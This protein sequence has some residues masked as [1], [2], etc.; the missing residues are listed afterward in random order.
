[1]TALRHMNHA[2]FGTLMALEPAIGVMLGLVVLHQRP[3]LVQTLGIVLVVVA[4]AAAARNGR[5]GPA[6]AYLTPE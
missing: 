4:G 3:S 2:A 5:R 1:M 6:A